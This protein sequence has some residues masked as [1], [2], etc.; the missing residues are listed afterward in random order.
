MPVFELNRLI[1]YDDASVLVEMR[2]VAALVVSPVLSQ[3][4]FRRHAKVS[5]SYVR[6]RFGSWRQALE[7][8]GIGDRYSGRTVSAKMQRKLA[9]RMTDNELLKEILRV[10]SPLETDTLSQE[11]F[12]ATSC[13]NARAVISR[14]GSWKSALQEAGLHLSRHGRRYS[15][16]DYFENL[17]AVWTFCARQ[18]YYREMDGAPSQITAGAY[19][20]KWGTWKKALVAFIERVNQDT[21]AE[22][23]QKQGRPALRLENDPAKARRNVRSIPL[24]SR[25]NVL[26]RDRFRCV[27]CGASPATKIGCV[28][29]VDHIRPVARGGKTEPDNL[30]T[31]CQGCNI[32]KSDKIETEN[33]G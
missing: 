15:D 6:R 3:R 4:E 11:A 5:P 8:A 16:D 7:K 24:G 21:A 29:H 26:R 25:Y 1:E 13:I 31:L 17:L 30:R 10:A 27:L 23:G 32:G 9:V 22:S 18:P 12:N 20:K 33:S 28:L 14:F 2:R 19:E